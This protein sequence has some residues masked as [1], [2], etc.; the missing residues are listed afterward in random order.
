MGQG[1]HQHKIK[2]EYEIRKRG[3]RDLSLFSVFMVFCGMAVC[4]LALLIAFTIC[5]DRISELL[6]GIGYQNKWNPASGGALNIVLNLPHNLYICFAKFMEASF[7][8]ILF[9]PL[10][11]LLV[12]IYNVAYFWDFSI[13]IYGYLP[14]MVGFA[15]IISALIASD[16]KIK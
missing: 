2:R 12:P 10:I 8:T 13:L 9:F 4:A 7:A 1:S 16:S 15:I 14:F 6:N 11:I 5:V 3:K